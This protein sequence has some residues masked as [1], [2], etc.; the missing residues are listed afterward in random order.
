MGSFSILSDST[1]IFIVLMILHKQKGGETY[2]HDSVKKFNKKYIILPAATLALIGIL[3]LGAVSADA[4]FSGGEYHDD[5]VKKLS[6]KLGVDQSKVESVFEEMHQEQQKEMETRL[7]DKLD[8]AVAQSDITATQKALILAKH[9][10]LQNQHES[11][12]DSFQD[13]T[14]QER[15]DTRQSERDELEKWATEQGIDL[16]YF[17][18]PMG[19]HF[20]SKG[21]MMK[22]DK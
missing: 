16:E 15:R 14:P 20:G 18:G 1:D 17:M 10:E 12:H 21:R 11:S 3:T 22:W 4:Y 6:E 19:G 13:T 2:M 8:E 9:E 5:M 7:M